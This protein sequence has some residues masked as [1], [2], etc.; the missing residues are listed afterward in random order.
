MTITETLWFSGVLNILYFLPG[1][2]NIISPILQISKQVMEIKNVPQIIV[3]LSSAHPFCLLYTKK[4]HL[5][6]GLFVLV[7]SA[8]ALSTA[9]AF[10][11]LTVR[12]GEGFP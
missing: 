1:K 6:P 3:S 2:G 5:M 9:G 4:G 10:Q 11:L 12:D 7:P 8:W